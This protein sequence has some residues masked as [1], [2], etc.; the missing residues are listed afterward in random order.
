MPAGTNLTN[1]IVTNVGNLEN[2]GIEFSIN[3]KAINNNDLDWE[4][5]FNVTY[6][7]NKITKLTAVDDSTYKGIYVGGIGGG[8][9]NNIQIHSVGYPSY[10]FY[11]Q[12]QV[13]DTEGNPIEG[14]YVD[15]NGDGAITGDDRYRYQK[16]A[17]TV[18]M[19]FTSLLRYKNLDFSFNG[20][21]N[22]G[23]YVYNNVFSNCNLRQYGS[24]RIP[25]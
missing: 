12:E 1:Q 2:K 9:G 11:V 23:N 13:Y 10:S 8:V 15:R 24:F 25:C 20:R 4:V 22:I 21:I 3:A 6:N 14:L 5:G 19:G 17:P 16:P 7:V 18:F